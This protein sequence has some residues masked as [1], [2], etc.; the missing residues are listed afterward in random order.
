MISF[1]THYIIVLF[2]GIILIV[3]MF[4]DKQN[5]NINFISSYCLSVFYIQLF[6]HI[7]HSPVIPNG[8]FTDL[9][10]CSLRRW[11]NSKHQIRKFNTITNRCISYTESAKNEKLLDDCNLYI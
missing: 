2:M 1:P 11:L 6:V 7:I 8:F 10:I 5:D 4:T 3:W 9:V